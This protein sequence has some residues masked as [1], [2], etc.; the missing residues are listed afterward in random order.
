MRGSLPAVSLHGMLKHGDKVSLLQ[1]KIESVI[2]I[3]ILTLI[4][5]YTCALV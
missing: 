2:E 5:W 4:V 1:Q 3:G